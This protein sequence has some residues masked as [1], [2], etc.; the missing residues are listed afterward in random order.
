MSCSKYRVRVNGKY[1]DSTFAFFWSW[2]VCQ[3][4]GSLECVFIFKISRKKCTLRRV[5]NIPMLNLSLYEVTNLIFRSKQCFTLLLQGLTCDACTCLVSFSFLPWIY[6][7]GEMLRHW[8][9]V[10]DICDATEMHTKIPP[11]VIALV[12]RTNRSIPYGKWWWQ[13]TQIVGLDIRDGNN[14]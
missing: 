10:L 12:S 13:G 11:L 2:S 1:V 6:I 3:N 8:M 5:E 7:C 4:N 9:L 14:S